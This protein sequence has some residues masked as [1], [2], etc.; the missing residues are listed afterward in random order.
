MKRIG[1]TG[2]IGS[3]K[4][5]VSQLLRVMGYPVYDT[6]S[7]A[8]RL[9]NTSPGL[10]AQIAE[11][12]GSDVYDGSGVLNRALLA[13]RVFGQA[14]CVTRLNAIVHPAVRQ[15]FFRWSRSLKDSVC[16]V[17]SAILYE[18]HFDELVDEVWVVAAPEEQRVERV[19]QRSGL[20]A[21][22]VKRRMASQLP[23]AEKRRRGN[24]V[25]WNDGK[26]SVIRAVLSLL[27]RPD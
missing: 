8:K 15:D 22:E 27:E 10:K 24:H 5:V 4:S 21:E 14:D 3:G 20:S 2:G 18:S 13:S 9:M 7:E 1:I 6:D 12:F 23:E 19:R 11:A 17:E 26:A 16:F 25:I